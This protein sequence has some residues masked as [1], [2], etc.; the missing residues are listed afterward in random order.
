M[1]RLAVRLLL[2]PV[3]AGISY[4]VIKLLGRNDNKM[5]DIVSFPGLMMQKITTKEPDDEQI[6]VAIAALKG[7]LESDEQVDS[8]SA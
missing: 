6:E 4:E 8:Q 2:F 3:I 1:L 7:A 5:A